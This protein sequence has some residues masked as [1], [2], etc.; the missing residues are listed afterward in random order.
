MENAKPKKEVYT[1]E[2]RDSDFAQVNTSKILRDLEG[3][4]NQFKLLAPF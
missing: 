3:H 1:A 4:V 2:F